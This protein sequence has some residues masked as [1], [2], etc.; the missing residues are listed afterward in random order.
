MSL[1]PTQVEV[2]HAGIV[3]QSLAGAFQGD[4]AVAQNVGIL[5]QLERGDDGLLD[6]Q[7]SRSTGNDLG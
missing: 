5:H 3:L 1:S 7:E 6:Q 4:A 2:E